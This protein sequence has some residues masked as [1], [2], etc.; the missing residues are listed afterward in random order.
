MA[1]FLLE[2]YFPLVE[3]VRYLLPGGILFNERNPSIM[4]DD[5]KTFYQVDPTVAANLN[6]QVSIYIFFLLPCP[7]GESFFKFF[8]FRKSTYYRWS[9]CFANAQ[10]QPLFC[11]QCLPNIRC[12]R[13]TIDRF[14]LQTMRSLPCSY[15]LCPLSSL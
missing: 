3:L 4:L 7:L 6:D 14:S 1:K 11:R 2:N 5:Y 12:L 8:Y 15:H 10:I 9:S 13:L